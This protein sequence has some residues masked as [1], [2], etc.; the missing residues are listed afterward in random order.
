MRRDAE[1]GRGQAALHFE[2]GSPEQIQDVNGYPS[3]TAAMMKTPGP[4]S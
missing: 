1:G 3:S 2:A 4:L